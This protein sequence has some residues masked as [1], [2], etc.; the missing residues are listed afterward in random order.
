METSPKF[1]LDLQDDYDIEVEK[2]KRRDI[3]DKISHHRPT[4]NTP[5]T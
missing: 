2:E 3:L 5:K 4:M 1:R